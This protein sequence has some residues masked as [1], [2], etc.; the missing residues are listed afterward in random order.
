[1]ERKQ[2]GLDGGI[3]KNK[4]DGVSDLMSGV[5]WSLDVGVRCGFGV[6]ESMV[7]CSLHR[8]SRGVGF[9]SKPGHAACGVVVVGRWGCRGCTASRMVDGRDG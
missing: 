7:Q 1:M 6:G 8:T 9:T 3:D 2:K 4:L 5:V